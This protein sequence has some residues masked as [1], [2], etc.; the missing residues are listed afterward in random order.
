MSNTGIQ[1]PPA[2]QAQYKIV[3]RNA[4]ELAKSMA[5]LASYGKDN[6]QVQM[7]IFEAFRR[8]ED[9]QH[10]CSDIVMAIA[11]STPEGIDSAV[12]A[13]IAAGDVKGMPPE[14]K[15]VGPEEA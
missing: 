7:S 5:E 11:F 2:V 3:T 1:A 14:L 6:P 8:L 12:N 15:I 9:S 13:A 10:R 4:T